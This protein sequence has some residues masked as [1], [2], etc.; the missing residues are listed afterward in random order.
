MK[1]RYKEIEKYELDTF[2]EKKDPKT[3][4][5]KY[6]SIGTQTIKGSKAEITW[7]KVQNNPYFCKPEKTK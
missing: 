5:I 4:R 2:V 7:A 3:G 1:S 6:E